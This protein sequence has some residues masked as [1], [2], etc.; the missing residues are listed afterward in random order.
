MFVVMI[1]FGIVVVMG[2]CGDGGGGGLPKSSP[3]YAGSN[4]PAIID[5]TTAESFFMVPWDLG[6]LVNAISLDGVAE[7]SDTIEGTVSGTLT[8]YARAESTITPTK[9]TFKE[10]MKYTFD[11]YVDDGS[12]FEGIL[13]GDGVAYLEE[14]MEVTYTG[15]EVIPEG[16]GEPLTFGYLSHQNF[17]DFYYSDTSNEQ[18]RSGWMTRESLGEDDVYKDPWEVDFGADIAMADYEG[19]YYLALLDAEASMAWDGSFTTYTGQGTVCV[20]G[21]AEYDIMGCFEVDFD[22]RW[23]ENSNGE[24]LEEFPLDGT[25]EYSTVNAS[26]M[27]AFGSS[28]SD[29]TCFLYS[30][31]EDGDGDYDFEQEYCD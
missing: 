21:E 26:A 4:N 25:A 18:E 19:N 23:D 2:G 11:N 27:F 29:P 24:P 7:T 22:F 17:S 16:V 31:D 15:E 14:R 10:L 5:S 13:I 20:E 8:I 28:P 1:S 3:S 30:V 6:D 12:S 9:D